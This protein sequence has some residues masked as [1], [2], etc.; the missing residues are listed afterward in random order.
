MVFELRQRADG[1]FFVRILYL[2]QTL[3]QMRDGTVLTGDHPPAR[4]PIF[5]PGCSQGTSGYDA[6]LEAF[7]AL[8]ARRMNPDWFDPSSGSIP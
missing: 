7:R 6:P 4:S 3:D 2:A 8:A 1:R 5:I